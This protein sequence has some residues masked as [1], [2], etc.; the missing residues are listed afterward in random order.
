[1]CVVSFGMEAWFSL[2]VLEDCACCEQALSS[3]K[4][5][6]QFGLVPRGC[7]VPDEHCAKYVD[8]W[9]FGDKTLEFCEAF[10]VVFKCGEKV[11]V[12]GDDP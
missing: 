11:V 4:C 3:S 7:A 12:R 6:E 10:V 1:M 9:P 2:T 8:G 5:M